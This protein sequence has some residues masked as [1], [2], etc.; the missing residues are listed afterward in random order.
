MAGFEDFEKGKISI[1]R[2]LKWNAE[3][4]ECVPP[5]FL[6]SPCSWGKRYKNPGNTVDNCASLSPILSLLQC[7][8]FLV[9]SLS[10]VLWH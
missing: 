6:P 8:P 4:D 7:I 1:S 3:T 5:I 2:M 9:D 10:R